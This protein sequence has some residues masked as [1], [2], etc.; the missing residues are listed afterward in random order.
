MGVYFQQFSLD[1]A[2]ENVAVLLPQQR[3]FVFQTQASY[4][5]T[6]AV[7]VTSISEDDAARGKQLLYVP[8]H[9]ANAF[10]EIGFANF[11][12]KGSVNLVG[13][14]FTTTDNS[15]SLPA[16]VTADIVQK[17]INSSVGFSKS[18]YVS[19]LSPTGKIKK[20]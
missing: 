2:N 3:E 6:R 14:R 17:L 9:K 12:V 10:A 18:G 1:I 7:N 20:Y 16:Y 11:F 5:F 13:E 8:L 19:S 4:S 15:Q